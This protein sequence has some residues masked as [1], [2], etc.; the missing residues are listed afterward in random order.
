M[1]I[2][3]T[4]SLDLRKPLD[5]Q[6]KSG[7]NYKTISHIDLARILE[8]KYSP[9]TLFSNFMKSQLALLMINSLNRA[10]SVKEFREQVKGRLREY[11]LTW[12]SQRG[13]NYF[14]TGNVFDTPLIDTA[15]YWR[16]VLFDIRMTS[17]ETIS[18]ERCLAGI[19][20]PKQAW[21]NFDIIM[22][23]EPKARYK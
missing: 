5:S 18:V 3:F 7:L 8:A 2:Y 6:W 20:S 21:H 16:N 9:Y 19:I 13:I 12:L 11:W 1:I 14:Q 23:P 15:Q 22:K 17:F 10:R 4:N